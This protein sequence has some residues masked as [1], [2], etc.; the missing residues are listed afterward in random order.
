MKFSG[1]HLI[2]TTKAR[3]RRQRESLGLRLHSETT[4][5][6]RTL[7]NP[8]RIDPTMDQHLETMPM[9]E[10]PL[11]ATHQ[12]HAS[13][14]EGARADLPAAIA[15]VNAVL[16]GKSRE[17]RLAFAS[18]LA[19][20]H[21]L[22]EDLPGMGKTTLAH[23]LAATLGLDFSRIQF[24]SDL[25]P[26]DIV[27][28]SIYERERSAFTFH[29]GPIFAEVVMADEINRATPKTQSA[30]LEAMAEQQ[31]TVD[32]ETH[33]LPDPFVV[34]ATQNPV[35]LAGTF[36]LPDSQLDRFLVRL[37]LG[38]P[39]PTSERA[40]LAEPDRR[41]LIDRLVPKLTRDGLRA[42]RRASTSVTQSPALIDYVQRLLAASRNAPGIAVGLSPR[43]GLA[44]LA[45]ARALALIDGRAYALPEDVQAAFVAVAAHRIVPAPD[46][47]RS[48][49]LLA[50]ALIERVAVDA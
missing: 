29:P 6:S 8:A 49:E 38:Y 37:A 23:A 18:V 50:H 15:Q 44:L 24:T 43:A 33:R 47:A 46:D 40:M 16:L 26:S 13:I 36:P 14:L 32:G 48:R 2:R 42:L 22:V 3:D 41:G 9:N 21:L 30:L 17:V 20:G 5:H 45:A 31:V 25:L 35:D 39:D 11:D 12:D 4:C 7:A 19:G 1:T 28:L 34:I 10:H 27:G